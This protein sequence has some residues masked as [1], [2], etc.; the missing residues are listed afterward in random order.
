MNTAPEEEIV[1]VRLPERRF[2]P[3]RTL[4]LHP[5]LGLLAYLSAGSGE[6]GPC[7]LGAA[8]L[9]LDEFRVLAALLSCLPKHC[10][11]EVAARALAASPSAV[12]AQAE[13]AT[14]RAAL[15]SV[16]EKLKGW[17]LTIAAVLETGYVLM[18]SPG[19]SPACAPAD[20]GG[21]ER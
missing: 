12:G 16:Q 2:P 21:T 15:S 6:S 9:T 3:E 17:G 1:Q 19:V 14:V 10:P 13:M 20:G 7:L 5:R 18:P 4:A 11:Y 8:L